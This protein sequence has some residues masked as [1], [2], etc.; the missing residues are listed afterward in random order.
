MSKQMWTRQLRIYLVMATSYFGLYALLLTLVPSWAIRL[1]ASSFD[2]G[3]LLAILPATGL[4]GDSI[5]GRCAARYG[6]RAVILL[7][8]GA[9]ATGAVVLF[10]AANYGTLVFATVVLGI[11]LS[12]MMTLILGGLSS[13]AERHQIRVQ[14][15]NAGW[16]R[17]GALIAA[18]F[19]LNVLT[20]SSQY[21]VVVAT[22]ALITTL[23]IA[24]LLLPSDAV[25]RRP[26][27][28]Q[29]VQRDTLERSVVHLVRSSRLVQGALIVNVV[30]PLLV[31]TGSSFLPFVLLD[32]TRPD[33]LTACLASRELVAITCAYALRNV[34]TNAHLGRT[35][36]IA[37]IVG[38]GCLF[39]LPFVDSAV[40]I[41]PLFSVHG[42]AIS[43]GIVLNNVQLYDG[44][45]TSNRLF[46]YAANGM[47]M[48]GASLILPLI[49]GMTLNVSVVLTLGLTATIAIGIA[50][51]YIIMSRRTAS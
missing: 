15:T 9:T 46:G 2:A 11:S 6:A 36:V 30:T 50:V 35:W 42:A 3:I 22:A 41:V 43:S 28:A 18:L 25:V 44:S 14:C 48:R 23:A 29:A 40:F 45:T 39:A 10:T 8:L 49:L 17:A 16:Q 21:L 33:L 26:P 1:G 19:L 20:P 47:V 13:Q 31:I 5:V 7:A 38:V 24:A 34:S 27:A 4:V 12:L 32:M 37:V 51:T